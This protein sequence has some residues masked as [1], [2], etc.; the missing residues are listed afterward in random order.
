[1]G[2]RVKHTVAVR[3]ARDTDFKKP[4]WNPDPTLEEVVT[5]A[6]EKQSNGNF[7]IAA[8]G[9]ENIPFGDVAAVKGIYLEVTA[10]CNVRLNGS[11]DDIVLTPNASGAVA[12]LFLEAVISQVTVENTDGSAA[13]EGVY[14]IWGDPTP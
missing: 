12:K 1:M 14:V 5:D 7:S 13:L 9:T 2:I 6:F 4:M 8:S 11:L 3:T 10:A